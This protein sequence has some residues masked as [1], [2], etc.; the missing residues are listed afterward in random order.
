M[1]D[2]NIIEQVKDIFASL[3]SKIT[4]KVTTDA[5]DVKKQELNDFL[6]DIASTSEKKQ[7]N[8]E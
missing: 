6:N 5:N 8:V 4:F 2:K 1:L 7:Y 3:K